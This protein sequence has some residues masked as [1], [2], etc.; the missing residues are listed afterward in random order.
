MTLFSKHVIVRA[1][2]CEVVHSY[3]SSCSHAALLAFYWAFKNTIW[4]YTSLY[5]VSQ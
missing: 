2:C 1:T 5:T 4:L 3:H